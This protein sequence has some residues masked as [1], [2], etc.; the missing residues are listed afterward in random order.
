MLGESPL[1]KR[2]Q[3]FYSPSVH[4]M[5][6]PDHQ[7]FLHFFH[8]LSK[9][10]QTGETM[11][12]ETSF[13]RGGRAPSQTSVKKRD[14]DFLFGSSEDKISSKKKKR[15]KTSTT[16]TATSLLPLGGGGVVQP[17]DK[18]KE[19]HIEA[20]SFT[21]LGKRT[22]LLATVREIHDEY[23]IVSLPNLLNG[24]ILKREVSTILRAGDVCLFNVDT[25]LYSLFF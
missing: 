12:E 8:S 9:K 23:A 19:A 13:P 6:F 17:S 14:A 25:L 11:S 18:K 21:K 10:H 2:N 1:E 20:L 5:S 15:R 7:T 16:T 22:K 3:E 24:Y 4:S